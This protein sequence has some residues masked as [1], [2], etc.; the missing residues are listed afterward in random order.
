[1]TPCH[2]VVKQ[3]QDIPEIGTPVN[4]A[5]INSNTTSNFEIHDV[6]INYAWDDGT[7]SLGC[8]TK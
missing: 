6:L 3:G 4:F 8:Q 7:M 5:S 2:L 1:M